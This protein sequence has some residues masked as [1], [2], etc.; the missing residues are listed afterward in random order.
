MKNKTPLLTLQEQQ[1]IAAWVES[2]AAPRH[3]KQIFDK[4]LKIICIM[5]TVTQSNQRL[6][7]R[8]ME[9]MGLLP[10]SES[11]GRTEEK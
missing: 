1:E 9:L 3:I 11:K 6:R 8:I 2:Q 5:A 4:M 7:Q 10:R